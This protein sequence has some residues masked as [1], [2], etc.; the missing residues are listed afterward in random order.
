MATETVITY[1]D[2]YCERAGEMGLLAEPLNALTNL[3]FIVAAIL[4]ASELWKVKQGFRVDLWLLVVFLFSIGVGSGLWHVF[5]TQHTMLMDVI[6]ITLFINL[7]LLSALRRLLHLGWG[8]TIAAWLAYFGLGMAAQFTLPPDLFNGTIMYIPTFVTL[9]V[10]TMVVRR[11][12]RGV[13]HVFGKVLLVWCASLVFRTID[14]L[15]CE[16]FPW[17]THFLWHMLNAW[18]LW[19]LLRVLI[20]RARYAQPH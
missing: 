4:A 13:G 2:A 6:P 9:L 3:F 18:V 14:P 7:Y 8:G 1:L 5:A 19:R 16:A 12:H 11:E 10:L 17:G 15:V 20:D